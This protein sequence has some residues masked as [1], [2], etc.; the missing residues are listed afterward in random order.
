MLVS[1]FVN[2][3]G[4]MYSSRK[5]FPRS[6]LC[7]VIIVLVLGKNEIFGKSISSDSKITKPENGSIKEIAKGIHR[8]FSYW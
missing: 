6:V 1:R 5:I 2:Q 8:R 4:T 7:L 3:T